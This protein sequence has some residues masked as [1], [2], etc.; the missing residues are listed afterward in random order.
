[1]ATAAEIDSLVRSDADADEIIAVDRGL[2]ELAKQ[3]V[4]LAQLVELKHFAGYTFD[5]AAVVMNISARQLRR[6]W[7]VAI[8]R[9]R[10][11]IDGSHS[12]VARTA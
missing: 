4:R 10:I 11:A 8:T 5:E 3:S 12:H 7:P 9:L 1:M 6:D 2:N